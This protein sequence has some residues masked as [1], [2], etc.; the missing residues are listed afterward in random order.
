[1][2][3]EMGRLKPVGA[4]WLLAGAS[5]P[6]YSPNKRGRGIVG[7]NYSGESTVGAGQVASSAS[8][9]VVFEGTRPENSSKFPSETFQTHETT[10]FRVLIMLS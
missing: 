7:H 10:L 8:L 2:G 9:A 5:W 4:L 3:R 1:M 6:R